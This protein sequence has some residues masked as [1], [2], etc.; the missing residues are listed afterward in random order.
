MPKAGL[1]TSVT[2]RGTWS[3]RISTKPCCSSN[4][5]Q[6]GF[7]EMRFDHVPLLVTDVISPAF[8]IFHTQKLSRCRTDS[9]GKDAQVRRSGL[10]SGSKCPGILVFSVG[11]K[12]HDFVILAF[13]ESC[14]SSFDG[15]RQ[16]GPAL[17]NDVNIQRID[18]LPE[19]GVIDGEWALQKRAS[20]E[21][22]Q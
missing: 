22:H 6:Q 15:L 2:S 11:E 14:Q 3:N 21:G 4:L 16:C 7:V 12:H 18:A 1:I 19:C 10:L 5:L 17:W 8:G 20:G 9:D 13:F